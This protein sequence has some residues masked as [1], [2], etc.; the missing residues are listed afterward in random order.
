M[1]TGNPWLKSWVVHKNETRLG[2]ITSRILI[3]KKTGTLERHMGLACQIKSPPR[4]ERVGGRLLPSI[5]CHV[6]TSSACWCRVLVIQL[7]SQLT[8]G[9]F[10]LAVWTRLKSPVTT[11]PK[12][13]LRW[14]P[15]ECLDCSPTLTQVP[16]AGGGGG[17]WLSAFVSVSLPSTCLPV[18]P[19]WFPAGLHF[20]LGIVFL[21]QRTRRSQ[22]LWSFS[23]GGYLLLTV[24]F[25]AMYC[26]ARWFASRN[27]FH[28]STPW[29]LAVHVTGNLGNLLMYPGLK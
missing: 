14:V 16:G 27:E 9:W 18:K 4:F 8:P 7:N 22:V 13:K 25:I 17:F 20:V 24:A 1:A 15:D 6:T 29:H 19:S 2:T 21:L 23:A 12:S 3:P 10:G 5:T 28:R 26:R 11:N